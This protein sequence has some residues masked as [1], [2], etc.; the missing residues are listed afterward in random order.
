MREVGKTQCD[1]RGRDYS[2]TATTQRAPRI[3]RGHQKLGAA[4]KDSALELLR[5][6]SSAAT[7]TMTDF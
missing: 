3:A 7:L 6:G 2:D 1:N 5:A 4:M